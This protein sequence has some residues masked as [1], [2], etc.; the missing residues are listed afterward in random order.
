M[1]TVSPLVFSL[2]Q[3]ATSLGVWL[4][5]PGVVMAVVALLPRS[6]NVSWLEL[7]VAGITGGAGAL[8][9]AVWAMS[10]DWNGLVRTPRT[11]WRVSFDGA[12]LNVQSSHLGTAIPRARI[13][14]ACVVA[15]GSWETLKGVE[16]Q[17][18]VL[19]VRGAL[20][21]SIPGSSEGF[22]GV[23]G[24]LDAAIGV[25]FKELGVE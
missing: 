6:L 18:L 12:T 17:C 2:W 23:R 24:A 5:L 4:L 7:A 13:R 22:E 8:G 25:G 10:N 1:R 20:Q 15:E 9:Y 14:S 21:I 16:D 11:P 19:Q 3:R